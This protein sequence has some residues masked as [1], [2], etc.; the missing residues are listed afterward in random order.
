MS[1][2]PDKNSIDPALIENGTEPMKRPA[3]SPEGFQDLSTTR[4]LIMP[5]ELPEGMP[6]PFEG[7]DHF[8]VVTTGPDTGRRFDVG[9]LPLVLGRREA[10]IKVA[11]PA[12]SGRHCRI[13]LVKSQLLIEDLSSSNGTYIN[14]KRIREITTLPVGHRLRVGSMEMRH[15]VGSPSELKQSAEADKELDRAVSYVESILPAPLDS[16]HI[17]IHYRYRP[18]S[19]LGGDTF[20]YEWIDDDHLAIYLIDVCGHGL[21]S[22]LHSVSVVQV[23]RTASL[24]D[25]DLRRPDQ[26]LRGLN[27]AFKM[28][29]H[30]GMYFTIWYGVYQPKTR[31]LRFASGGHPPALLV[32]DESAQKLWT[33]QPPIGMLDETFVDDDVEITQNSRLFVFSDGAFEL[34]KPDDQAWTLDELL[35]LLGQSHQHPPNTELDRIEDQLK[36]VQG[37]EQFDDDLSILLVDFKV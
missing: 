13:T 4:T 36:A 32:T 16:S 3:S 22:A 14:G 34:V 33:H 23:L 25:V 31:R 8:L 20:S 17:D 29:R 9:S 10:Q 26:V 12:V 2:D 15:E 5:T 24:P 30:G 21:H 27:E 35:D 1:L 18:S 11:D 28:S 19:R 7:L 37:R 6:N